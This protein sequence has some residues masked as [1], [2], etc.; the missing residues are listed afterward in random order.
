M[1]EQV[2]SA[3][4]YHDCCQFIPRMLPLLRLL[5]CRECAFGATMD[6]AA[7]HA[8]EGAQKKK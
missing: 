1:I 8:C 5:M 7:I 6:K 4:R 2:V 3:S